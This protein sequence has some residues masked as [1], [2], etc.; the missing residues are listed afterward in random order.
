MAKKVL[1]KFLNLIEDSKEFYNDFLNEDFINEYIVEIDLEIKEFLHTSEKYSRG[2]LANN[3]LSLSSAEYNCLYLIGKVPDINSTIIAKKTKQSKG[4][5]SKIIKKLE[6]KHLITVYQ[7]EENKKQSF[8]KLTSLGI[9]QF[10]EYNEYVEKIK[11][12]Y[13]TFFSENFTEEELEFIYNFFVKINK[14]RNEEIA[15]IKQK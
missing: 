7:K 1:K 9:V 5:I 11:K 14:F 2:I 4:N 8:F 10:N 12:D 6:M 15:K 3:S 13:F